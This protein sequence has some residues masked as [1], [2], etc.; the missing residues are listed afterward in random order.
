MG[1]FFTEFIIIF[2]WILRA[3]CIASILIVC[4]AILRK[5]FKDKLAV[6]FNYLL[7]IIIF[8][9]LVVPMF[10][11]SK[12]SVFNYIERA[13][14]KPAVIYSDTQ[15]YYETKNNERDTTIN[16]LFIDKSKEPVV[17]DNSEGINKYLFLK[18]GFILWILGISILAAVYLA[19]R[20]IFSIKLMLDKTNVKDSRIEILE[21]GKKRVGY[22]KNIKLLES[23]IVKSPCIYGVFKP[24]ILIPYNLAASLSD[25]DLENIFIHEISHM[26][27]RDTLRIYLTQI[28]LV[29]H[30]FNPLVWY[31]YKM[32]REDTELCCDNKALNKLDNGEV[33]N[34]GI[35]IIKLMSK[36]TSKSKI[37]ATV[38]AL[39]TKHESKRRIKMISKYKRIT[40]KNA[41]YGTILVL[42]FAMTT[43]TDSKALGI[44]KYRN[45]DNI[46]VQ[47]IEDKEVLGNWES[48]DFV[49]SIESFNL[50]KNYW[51][52]EI[53]NFNIQFNRDGSTQNSWL[54]WTKGLI[55]HHGDKTASKYYIKEIEGNKY[56]FMEWKSGDYIY[57]GEITGYYVLKK[58]N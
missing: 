35:T 13:S 30:W 55:M 1:K 52:K 56:L 14:E 28:I 25:K 39:G 23:N 12:F 16:S 26:K 21:R 3:S 7:W 6:E 20:I 50:D 44:E 47:F 24:K 40:A 36:F 22:Y 48:I 19:M 31:A 34:Y 15:S 29:V 38:G 49:P 32:F 45:I 43:L 57:R 54:T 27:R 51:N 2:L 4:V 9:R 42:V 10:P 33:K 8:L 18:Y 11:Q 58:A 5:M 41:I 17:I 37:A 46:N 53:L